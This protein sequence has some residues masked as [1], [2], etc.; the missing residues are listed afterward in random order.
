[1]MTENYKKQWKQ[2]NCNRCEFVSYGKN[3]KCKLTNEE[4]EELMR[5]TS[6]SLEMKLIREKK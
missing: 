2:I 6:C 5:N 1:M 3:P 4:K